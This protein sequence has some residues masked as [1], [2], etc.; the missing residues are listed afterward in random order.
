MGHVSTLTM[1]EK[2]G[3]DF[4]ADVMQWKSDVEETCKKVIITEAAHEIIKSDEHIQ[5]EHDLTTSLKIKV[6][7]PQFVNYN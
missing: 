7:V 4:N 5:S 1:I 2:L 3:K 6:I